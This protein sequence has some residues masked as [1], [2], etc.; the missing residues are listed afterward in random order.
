MK[1][2]SYVLEAFIALSMIALAATG[3]FAAVPSTHI[4]TLPSQG[5]AV[6]SYLDATGLLRRAVA[7]PNHD[8]DTIRAAIAPYFDRFEV[9]FCEPECATPSAS[10]KAALDYFIAGRATYSPVHIRLYLW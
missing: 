8:I 3:L 2:I 7:N 4:D 10:A 5:D 1:G 6:L 9:S